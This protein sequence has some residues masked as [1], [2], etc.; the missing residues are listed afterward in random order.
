MKRTG[1][2]LVI[3]STPALAFA[4]AY[5]EHRSSAAYVASVTIVFTVVLIAHLASTTRDVSQWSKAAVLWF[6]NFRL[7]QGSRIF[8]TIPHTEAIFYWIETRVLAYAFKVEKTRPTDKLP[9]TV[10]IVL[11]RRIVNP[12]DAA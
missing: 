3:V 7:N 4:E 1:F 11:F 2:L 10:D 12:Q 5:P 9:V 8:L 6:G